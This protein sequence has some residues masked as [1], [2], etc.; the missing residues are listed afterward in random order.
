MAL[1]NNK[2]RCYGQGWSSSPRSNRIWRKGRRK[3]WTFSSSKSKEMTSQQSERIT[4]FLGKWYGH[5]LRDKEQHLLHWET[6]EVI[7]TIWLLTVWDIKTEGVETNVNKQIR[8][9]FH[10]SAVGPYII[11]GGVQGDQVQGRCSEETQ[12]SWSVVLERQPGKLTVRLAKSSLK[13]K[14]I[15]CNFCMGW[16][17]NH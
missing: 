5:T 17:Q 14:D 6:E 13:L 3:W 8:T 7:W 15:I 9:W 2:L 1:H 12:T 11:N 16:E 10:I 4:R